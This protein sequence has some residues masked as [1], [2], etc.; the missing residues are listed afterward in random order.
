MRSIE[1]FSLMPMATIKSHRHKVFQ[2]LK[3]G[4]PRT[5]I[6]KCITLTDNK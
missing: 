2:A 6:V 3:Q 4:D 5:Y 1:S